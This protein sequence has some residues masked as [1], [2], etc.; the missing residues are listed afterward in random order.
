MCTIITV[1]WL[2]WRFWQTRDREI[3]E[4]FLRSS[5]ISRAVCWLRSFRRPNSSFTFLMIQR[6]NNDFPSKLNSKRT[7]CSLCIDVFGAK[8]VGLTRYLTKRLHN[9]FLYFG[10]P[11]RWVERTE[12]LLQLQQSSYSYRSIFTMEKYMQYKASQAC[13]ST[14][15]SHHIKSSLIV[16][17]IIEI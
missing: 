2:R 6:L 11:S 9:P 16:E 15:P 8:C 12:N 10:N 5:V 13:K 1:N 3:N 17:Q 4:H 14:F 7:W